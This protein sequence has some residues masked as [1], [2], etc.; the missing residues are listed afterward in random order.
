MCQ[1]DAPIALRT[2]A[3]AKGKRGLKGFPPAR[4]ERN[5]GDTPCH[6][7]RPLYNPGQYAAPSRFVTL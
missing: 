2:Y 5:R 7:K 4:L 1:L 3:V 6:G